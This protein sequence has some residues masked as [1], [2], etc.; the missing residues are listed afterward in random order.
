MNEFYSES[1]LQASAKNNVEECK[2]LMSQGVD[3]NYADKDGTSI[4]HWYIFGK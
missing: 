4:E 2:K 3:I 1:F